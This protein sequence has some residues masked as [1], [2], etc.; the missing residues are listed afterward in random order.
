[1]T[2]EASLAWGCTMAVACIVDIIRCYFKN[3]SLTSVDLRS[4]NERQ[5]QQ[6]PCFYNTLDKTT[7]GV[8][9][10]QPTQEIHQRH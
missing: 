7:K 1:M 5:K 6:L 10:E 9:H 2:S 3:Y 4:Y 8:P